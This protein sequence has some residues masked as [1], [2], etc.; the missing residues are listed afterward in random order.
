MDNNLK[1]ESNNNKEVEI[2]N[3][4]I[5]EEKFINSESERLKLEKEI[6][7]STNPKDNQIQLKQEINIELNEEIKT[8]EKELEIEED[9]NSDINDDLLK[10]DNKFI[11]INKI[12]TNEVLKETQL[13]P[14]E[15]L[16]LL[17][18]ELIFSGKKVFKWEV[19][20]TPKE[21][22]EFFKK[23]YKSINKDKKATNSEF[24]E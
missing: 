14:K 11:N 5:M 18:I 2:T 7:I 6:E 16:D 17:K 15:N 24:I 10:I 21:T 22:K 1:N 12:K 19:Y 3:D 8:D 23:L 13:E 9:E 20:R 4:N